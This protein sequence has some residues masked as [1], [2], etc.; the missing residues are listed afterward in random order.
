MTYRIAAIPD[1]GI[2][3]EVVQLAAAAV[4]QVEALAE[5]SKREVDSPRAGRAI[6]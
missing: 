3:K 5:G 1:D 6:Q 2:S 4:L